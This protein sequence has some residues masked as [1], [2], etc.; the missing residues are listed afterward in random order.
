MI[1]VLLVY[2]M[3]FNVTKLVLAQSCCDHTRAGYVQFDAFATFLHEPLIINRHFMYNNVTDV[4]S[5]NKTATIRFENNHYYLDDYY[6]QFE[7]RTKVCLYKLFKHHEDIEHLVFADG[8]RPRQI[9][10]GCHGDQECCEVGC[11]TINKYMYFWFIY[12]CIT[13]LVVI[14]YAARKK[15][16]AEARLRAFRDAMN[17]A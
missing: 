1:T 16:V 3:A 12:P 11:C 9:V 6:E 17:N 5:I 2:L 10:F 7:N 13:C 4:Y 15:R 8:T 14:A